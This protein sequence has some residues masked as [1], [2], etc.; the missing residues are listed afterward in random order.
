MPI[1]ECT[2]VANIMRWFSNGIAG[3][4]LTPECAAKLKEHIDRMTD[5]RAL[6]PCSNCR[7]TP[8]EP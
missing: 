7:T 5:R 2:D 1:T 4:H 3:F 6:C 8:T